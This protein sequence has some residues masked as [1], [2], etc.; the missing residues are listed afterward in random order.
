[1]STSRMPYLLVG[2][3]T[4]TDDSPLPRPKNFSYLFGGIEVGLNILIFTTCFLYNMLPDH[5]FCRVCLGGVLVTL[6]DGE[7]IPKDEACDE[8]TQRS[9]PFFDNSDD[10]NTDYV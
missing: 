2:E 6:C 3:D 9:L 8:H 4:H 10:T 5:R 1:M 7:E